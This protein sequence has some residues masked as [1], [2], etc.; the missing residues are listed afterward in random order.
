MAGNNNFADNL[1]SGLLNPKG[2]LGDFAHASRT[3]V[4]DFFR[5]APKTKFLYFVK[6][7][8]SPQAKDLFSKFKE[9]HLYESALLV[10]SIDLPSMNFNVQTKNAYNRKKNYLTN[11]TYDPINITLHDD[12]YSITTALM[13][14]YYRYNFADGNSLDNESSRRFQPRNT[15]SGSN[16]RIYRYGLDY[17]ISGEEK[18][19]PFFSSFVVYQFARRT[20]NSFTLVNPVISQIQHDTMDQSDSNPAEIKMTRLYESVLYD[21]GQIEPLDNPEGF[22]QYGY[23]NTPS[24]LS[25]EG[26]GIASFFSAGGAIE[27]VG[28]LAAAL[29]GSNPNL[30][31]AAIIGANLYQNSKDLD[32][33]KFKQEATSVA[34]N[35]VT[36][37]RPS[38]VRGQASAVDADIRTGNSVTDTTSTKQKT[39]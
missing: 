18:K 12:N 9:R 39:R 29:S 6:W 11:I 28:A 31:A 27:G 7:N 4:D 30:G 21:Q 14:A 19:E 3:Y 35:Q 32:S 36:S 17:D 37:I 16:D 23:D 1:L 10:K 26:G 25:L 22:T 13:E 2:N 5:R 34:I 20:Y 8:L 24:P 33:E 15:Y 38:D